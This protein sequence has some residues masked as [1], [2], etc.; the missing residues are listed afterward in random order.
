M[1]R[2]MSS[3]RY[4]LKT[5]FRASKMKGNQMLGMQV[6]LNTTTKKEQVL[7]MED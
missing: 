7:K 1:T 6:K 3:I 2:N 5:K 4:E